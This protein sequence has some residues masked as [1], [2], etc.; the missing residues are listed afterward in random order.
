M[1]ELLWDFYG[2]FPIRQ[3]DWRELTMPASDLLRLV[4]LARSVEAAATSRPR[5]KRKG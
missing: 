3:A 4:R 5:A 2:E 1:N